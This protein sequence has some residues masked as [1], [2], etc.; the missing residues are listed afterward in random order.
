M[1]CPPL[2]PGGEEV[3]TLFRAV[4][5]RVVVQYFVSCSCTLREL[6]LVHK[7]TWSGSR[8]L[9]SELFCSELFER[10]YTSCAC[11]LGELEPLHKKFEC[12]ICVKL[13]YAVPVEI[14]HYCTVLFGNSSL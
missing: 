10:P 6:E 2:P 13:C 9:C 8:L 14:Y 1:R 5:L 4:L 12:L 3:V 11:T 7:V